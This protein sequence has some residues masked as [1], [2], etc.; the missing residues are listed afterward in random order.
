MS[1]DRFGNAF[2]EGVS[3]ARG[4]ILPSTADDIVKLRVAWSHISR[5]RNE[6]GRDSIYLLSGLERNLQLEDIDLSVMDDE[7]AS[8]LFMD[9]LT[10]RSLE[11]LG[12]V[13]PNHDI[14]VFNHH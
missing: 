1:I 7:I 12:G 5:R 11:H 9:E 10:E 4:S 2:A 14:F 6:L 8:A 13:A 3:Y